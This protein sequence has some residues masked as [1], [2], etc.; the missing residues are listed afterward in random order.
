MQNQNL[1]VNT[2]QV[3]VMKAPVDVDNEIENINNFR[4]EVIANPGII[5]VTGSS[6]IPGKEVGMHLANRLFSEEPEKNKLYEML[7]TDYHFID[8]YNLSILHGR[9]FSENFPT[10]KN[11]LVI[12]E[13]AARYLGF[14]N[15]KDALNKE[16]NI[17]EMFTNNQ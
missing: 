8:T 11:A 17:E 2:N 7:R 13:T 5:N 16:V 15:P 14:S 4:A 9:G 10:D 12:S 1:G 6:S 3:L